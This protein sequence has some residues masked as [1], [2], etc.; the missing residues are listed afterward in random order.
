MHHQGASDHLLT[1][2]YQLVLGDQLIEFLRLTPLAVLCLI[3]PVSAHQRFDQT[4]DWWHASV[5][6]FEIEI[7]VKVLFSS[8]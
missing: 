2:R 1:F 5:R 8:S 3:S 4:R 6:V 7:L